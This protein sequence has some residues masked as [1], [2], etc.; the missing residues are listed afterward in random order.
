M[1]ICP[2]AGSPS[3][4]EPPL[5]DVERKVAFCDADASW[6]GPATAGAKP[7]GAATSR[8]AAAAEEEEGEEAERLRAVVLPPTIAGASG[9]NR[10][11]ERRDPLAAAQASANVCMALS[12]SI[13]ATL[14]H[15]LSA[16][17]PFGPDRAGNLG[18]A[19][20]Q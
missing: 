1:G 4:D 16:V 12:K 17:H 8:P 14:K 13:L 5:A 10:K 20:L 9:G 15:R 7:T 18:F 6:Q 2:R 19:V 3:T 11:K